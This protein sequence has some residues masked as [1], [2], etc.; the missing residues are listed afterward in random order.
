MRYR[1]VKVPAK[2]M[3][4]YKLT[5]QY[6][7]FE[8]IR[9][10]IEYDEKFEKGIAKH[11]TRKMCLDYTKHKQMDVKSAMLIFNSKTA[12]SIEW[13]I[14]NENWPDEARTTA[15]YCRLWARWYQIMGAYNRQDGF[16]TEKPEERQEKIDFLIWFMD[17]Y[18]NCRYIGGKNHLS[19]WGN[20][21]HVICSTCTVIWLQGILLEQDNFGFFLPGYILGNSV[22]NLHQDVRH[23]NPLPTPQLYEKIL[24]GISM[25]QLFGES[26]RGASYE[27]DHGKNWLVSLSDHKKLLEANPKE[28]ANI[29]FFD[30]NELV[31]QDYTEEVANSFIGGGVLGKVL[32]NPD[33]TTC[34]DFW[35][36]TSETADNPLNSLIEAR[37]TVTDGYFRPSDVGHKIL[38]YA[39][40]L[41]VRNRDLEIDK[42]GLVDAFVNFLFEKINARF[43][44][45]PGCHFYAVVKKLVTWKWYHYAKY[46]NT[47]LTE[48]N[49]DEIANEMNASKTTKAWAMLNAETGPKIPDWQD[50]T[51]WQKLVDELP[52]FHSG[53]RERYECDESQVRNDHRDD[54]SEM[55][56]DDF[57]YDECF[58]DDDRDDVSNESFGEYD[59]DDVSNRT[60][61]PIIINRLDMADSQGFLD[62]FPIETEM[63]D[64]QD[65]EMETAG[66]NVSELAEGQDKEMETDGDNVSERAEG[67]EIVDTTTDMPVERAQSF[68]N[69]S[70]FVDFLSQME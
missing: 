62:D 69:A 44:N 20:Q 61:G 30:D 28:K 51:Q 33:C 27:L 64:G 29:E 56:D 46:L 21:K 67:P 55:V 16:D 52:N 23:I 42:K 68:A 25:T 41:F 58:G 43:E 47:D 14:K 6:A 36:E 8:W 24:R 65:K 34:L 18:A 4:K 10:L 9:K 37:E 19:L 32:E 70:D 2:C 49:K 54:I 48:I 7:K 63:A 50:P 3:E 59:R 31:G 66:D 38:Q 13:M 40:R 12:D 5:S 53:D 1:A 15:V 45:I 17:F 35:K 11:L 39:D 57:D 60:D 26:V 22:E